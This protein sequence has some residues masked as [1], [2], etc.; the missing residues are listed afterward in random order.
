M[1]AV[2]A[3]QIAFGW[4]GGAASKHL[5]GFAMPQAGTTVSSVRHRQKRLL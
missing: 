5:W 2:S 3:R 4:T 1:K